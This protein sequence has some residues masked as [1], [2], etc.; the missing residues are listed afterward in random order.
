MLDRIVAPPMIQWQPKRR[1]LLSLHTLR[2]V[3]RYVW[4]ATAGAATIL[5]VLGVIMSIRTAYGTVVIELP[6]LKGNKI[7]VKIDGNTIDITEP[8]EPLRLK[9]GEH[10]LEVSFTA[11]GSAAGEAWRLRVDEQD[12]EIR[13]GDAKMLTRSFSICR[14]Q[15]KVV[16]VSLDKDQSSRV[17]AC[18]AR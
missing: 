6:D 16:N 17:A 2:R 12:A 4:I 8:N 7:E 13:S 10:G 1:V 18:R 9:V 14:G 11:S 5:L 15:E 3:P